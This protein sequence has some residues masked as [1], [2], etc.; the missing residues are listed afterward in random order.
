MSRL[1]P[2]LAATEFPAPARHAIDRAARLAQ[3][4]GAPL[5]LMH[6]LPGAALQQL[7]Q[8]LGAGHAM[9][10][11]LRDSARQQLRHLAD[12]LK[13][14]RH[15]S[16][17]TVHGVGSVLDDILGQAGALDAAL[18]VLGARGAGFMRRLALGST[19]ERL[20]RRTTRPPLAVRQ[21][22][23]QPY[24]H[25][26]VAPDFPPWSA[27]AIPPARLVAPHARL[28]LFSAYQVPFEEKL[29]FAGVDA[30]TID[31]YRRQTRA[32]AV[33]RAHALAAASGLRPAAFRLGGLHRR[34][35][36]RPSHRRA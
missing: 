11:H 12:E 15:V 9:E 30:A 4:T 14:T 26:L 35:R 21:T 36:R 2:I 33:Q 10:E 16:A 17:Q 20:L 1:G 5:T 13:A 19:S 27:R 18:V 25:V 29:H 34:R 32:D 24:R 3:E 7:R 8:W 28:L 6:V 22:P 31:H 23:H